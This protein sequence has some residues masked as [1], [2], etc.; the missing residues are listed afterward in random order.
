MLQECNIDFSV[1]LSDGTAYG[2][3]FGKLELP[4][5]LNCQHTLSLNPAHYPRLFGER[6]IDVAE[7][8]KAAGESLSTIPIQKIS[9]RADSAVLHVM[10]GDVV[11]EGSQAQAVFRFLSSAFDLDVEIWE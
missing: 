11:V 3:V 4:I 10:L 2:R 8:V 6:G 7:S 5:G 9:V 1:F